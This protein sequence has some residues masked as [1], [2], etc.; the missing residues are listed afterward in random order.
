MQSTSPG[1]AFITSIFSMGTVYQARDPLLNPTGNGSNVVTRLGDLL[2]E[3]GDYENQL[4]I[5]I[6]HLAARLWPTGNRKRDRSQTGLCADADQKCW[7]RIDCHSVAAGRSRNL[8]WKSR[9]QCLQDTF[10]ANRLVHQRRRR[11]RADLCG[12]VLANSLGRERAYPDGAAA[13]TQ[14]SARYLRRAGYRYRD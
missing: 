13:I 10:H 9:S 12:A 7:N 4:G 2:I 5:P 1:P 3:N 6:A 8:F 11:P 14:C